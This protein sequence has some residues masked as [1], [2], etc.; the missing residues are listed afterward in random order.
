[1]TG[2]P[3]ATRR[4]LR[5]S[6][7]KGRVRRHIAE[8]FSDR[9]YGQLLA[10][11]HPR[12]AE[13]MT[14]FLE[15]A[16]QWHSRLFQPAMDRKGMLQLLREHTLAYAAVE[17]SGAF[18]QGDYGSVMPPR[19]AALCRVSLDHLLTAIYG[20]LSEKPDG[21]NRIQSRIMGT[22]NA[23]RDRGAAEEGWAQEQPK[24][25]PPGAPET[26][27]QGV[28]RRIES[29]SP[30]AADRDLKALAARYPVSLY[31]LLQTLD[32]VHLNAVLHRL[33]NL[34]HD[35]LDGLLR[36]WLKSGAG[37]DAS[38][39]GE[40]PARI[41]PGDLES[42]AERVEL[43]RP[44]VALP[45]AEDKAKIPTGPRPSGDQPRP[46]PSTASAPA[47]DTVLRGPPPLPRGRLDGLL[48]SWLKGGAGTDASIHGEMPGRIGP[49]DLESHAER[50]ELLRSPIALSS[51][52]DKAKIPIGPRPGSGHPRPDPS[53]AASPA[54]D[55]PLE[56]IYVLNAGLVLASAYLPRL[57]D[58][59]GLVEKK[60]FINRDATERAIHLLEVLANN[61]TAAPEFQLAL[62]KVLCGVAGAAPIAG[63]IEI[64]PAEQ[65]AVDGLIRSMIAHWKALGNTSPEGLR[66]AFLQREGFLAL[67]GDAW[68]LQVQGRSYD[69]LLDRLPWPYTPVKYPWMARP[70]HV[71]WR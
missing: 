39:R 11:I 52:E 38:R 13:V 68:H 24:I 15:A 64:T 42:H 69:M 7:Q 31:H 43:L 71:E 45:A 57:F 27:F 61:R 14:A 65:E 35:R 25:G 37:T 54:D 5:R 63:G 62:N 23:I 48:R 10:L 3:K 26:R 6:L 2:H 28:V 29:G 9:R 30:S 58:M 32:A 16:A 67:K 20:D 70:I 33:A 18:D 51:T 60:R 55:A 8:H 4:L 50:A 41:G 19:M 12:H 36:S 44:L 46:D 53:M 47:L 1:L 49:I 34:P 40:M 66:T 17:P 21:V 22:L 59:L 56:S